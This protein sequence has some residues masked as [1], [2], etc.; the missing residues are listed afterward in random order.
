VRYYLTPIIGTGTEDNP[1]QPKVANY[2]CNWAAAYE[3]PGEKTSIVAVNATPVVFAQI[4]ADAD[5]T[6]L[7]DN[8]EDTITSEEF[9][10]ICPNGAVM[11]YG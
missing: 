1:Y 9:Q 7:A 8:L 2:Q 10:R 6:L 5:I 4:D 3:I 11:V